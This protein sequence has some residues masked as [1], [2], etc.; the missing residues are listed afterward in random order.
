MN[1]FDQEKDLN[2]EEIALLV[3]KGNID[4]YEVLISRYTEKIDRYLRK[5]LSSQEDV[6]D[7][8]QDIFIKCFVNIQSFDTDQRFSPWIYRI[9]HNEAVNLLKKNSSRPF[10]F[11]IFS[12]TLT[13]VHPKA[14]EN[15]EN[16]A[17]KELIK[18]YLDQILNDLDKKYK[19]IIV[20]YFYEDMSYKDISDVLKIPISLV[21]VRIQRGKEQI[22]KILKE[23]GLEELKS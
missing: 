19:E 3:Q 23:R 17:E 14:K 8:L 4:I 1:T 22:K 6:E 15:S 12:E 2:D 10:S 20:L 13:F 11:D 7:I 21:G 18:N 16:E 9:A 5:F